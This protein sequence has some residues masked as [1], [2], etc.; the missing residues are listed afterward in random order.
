[1]NI[2]SAQKDRLAELLASVTA[3]D[4]EATG[5]Q[6]LS[7]DD[8]KLHFIQLCQRDI[9]FWT[10]FSDG[11]GSFDDVKFEDAMFGATLAISVLSRRNKIN[12]LANTLGKEPVIKQE[13]KQLNLQLG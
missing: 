5:K 13:I 12:S 10:K 6:L 3:Q 7:N 1:M 11:L 9:N 2:I 4:I 8:R